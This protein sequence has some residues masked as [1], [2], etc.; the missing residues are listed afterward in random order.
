M[1][2]FSRVRNQTN[3]QSSLSN[4]DWIPDD[5]HSY[6]VLDLET[7]GL[8]PYSDRILEIGLVR[9][10]LSGKAIG[11][12]ST[13]VNPQGPVGAT[14]IHGIT[15]S[16]VSS[17][18]TFA[19]CVEE[20][21]ARIQGQVVVAHNASFDYSFMKAELARQGWKIPEIPVICTML[22][23]KFFLPG[24]PRKRLLD[25]AEAIGVK[26]R[27]A[28]RALDDAFVASSLL[29]FYLNSSVDPQRSEHLRML[30][31]IAAT[32]R[33]PSAPGEPSVSMKQSTRI[34]RV[35][36]PV[37]IEL[38]KN[39]SE[40]MPEDLLGDEARPEEISYAS[41]L[42]NSIED[43]QI[44][45]EEIVA[46]RECAESFGLEQLDTDG[47]HETLLM[48]LAR[49]AWRDGSVSRSE[50]QEIKECATR[51]GL[52]SAVAKKCL[53]EVEE[54]RASRISARAKALPEDWSLGEPLRV[55]DRIV[56]TGCYEL[57][58]EELESRARKLGL[59][60][61]GSVSGKT[62]L[63]VSDGAI[64]GNKDADARRL[65]LRVI[66]PEQLRVLLEYVQPS[67]GEAPVAPKNEQRT[68]ALVDQEGTTPTRTE[69]LTCSTCGQIFVR[70]VTRGRK[71]HEC[72]T[73]RTV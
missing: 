12:W 58:R 64:N 47:I 49:E 6:V 31:T 40:L 66:R 29:Q 61:T 8:S 69:N 24:I 38:L 71:P 20:I 44:S 54:L 25:C 34:V 15:Q 2:L 4:G 3:E 57:G 46:L 19:E 65:G 10:D 33:W 11:H 7:T 68:T 35:S 55:G 52:S 28:H 70:I 42:L 50:S 41:L 51:L 67:V 43:G 1:G 5:S 26:Q 72:E 62:T 48:T 36:A 63:L 32:T 30:P 59:R 73:C 18:P 22:E 9:V 23:S 13:L 45:D 56:I 37:R 14:H 21:I 39:V 17:A 60:V 27:N 16:D 53:S